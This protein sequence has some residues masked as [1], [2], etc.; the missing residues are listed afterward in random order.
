[1]LEKH[2]P[3]SATGIVKRYNA[4]HDR[5]FGDGS[6]KA[7]AFGDRGSKLEFMRQPGSEKVT[8]LPRATTAAAAADHQK[9][10]RRKTGIWWLLVRSIMDGLAFYG[11]SV[12]SVGLFPPDLDPR[13]RENPASKDI[14]GFRWRGPVRVISSKRPQASASTRFDRSVDPAISVGYMLPNQREREIR[15]AVAALAK[16]DDRTLLD[17]GIPHRSYVE[18]TVRYCHDC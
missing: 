6:L 17:L 11:A 15:K 5:S 13:E 2:L 4:P 1:M 7:G 9:T 14:A 10:D 8:L 18:Q 3:G 12:H 16:L